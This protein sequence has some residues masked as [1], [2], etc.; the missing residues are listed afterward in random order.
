MKKVVHK[1]SEALNFRV[2]FEQDEDGI[3]IA[4]VPAIPGCHT[5]GDTYEEAIKNIKEAIELCLEVAKNSV[6]YKSK[7]DFGESKDEKTRFL[8]V[9]Q[10]PVRL[11]FSL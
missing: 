2:I 4:S 3:F 8:G 10:V 1:T 9:A 11:G 6:S 5:Q 7:I